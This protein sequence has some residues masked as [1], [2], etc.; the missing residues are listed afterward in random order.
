MT[1][2]YCD[3][4]NHFYHSLASPTDNHLNLTDSPVEKSIDPS[5]S[6]AN[7]PTEANT[8]QYPTPQQAIKENRATHQKHSAKLRHMEGQCEG[9]ETLSSFGFSSRLHSIGNR[10][11]QV[12][13]RDEQ[14]RPRNSHEWD[15]WRTKAAA[16]E[17]DEY[18]NGHWIESPVERVW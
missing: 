17:T 18:Q 1:T 6:A 9:G 4:E 14:I 10:E 5:Y 7:R 15:E 16:P 3:E 2:D 12:N 11:D 13:S 8:E